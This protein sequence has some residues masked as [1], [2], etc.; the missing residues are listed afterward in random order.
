MTRHILVGFFAALFTLPAL[1]QKPPE[2]ELGFKPDKVYSFGTPENVNLFNGNLM[3]TVPI[4]LRYPVSSQMSYGLTL[5]YNSKAWDFWYDE[6]RFNSGETAAWS[7][8]NIRSN[9][10]M[11]W[12]LSLG[13][14]IPP[15]DA[16]NIGYTES[17]NKSWVY[18]GPGGDEHELTDATPTSAPT[19]SDGS[20]LRMRFVDA[21]HREIQFP[22]GEVHTFAYERQKW[23]LRSMADVAGNTVTVEYAYVLS[24]TVTSH[25]IIGD[26]HGRQHVVYFT[27]SPYLMD[28]IDRGQIVDR[29]VMRGY[30]ADVTY[31]FQYDDLRVDYT[32]GHT[33]PV[34]SSAYPDGPKEPRPMVTLL[35]SVTLPDGSKWTFDYYLTTGQ[36]CGSGLLKT[37]TL[38]TLGST[39][40]TYQQ[41]TIPANNR[42]HDDG[43]ANQSPGI[44]TRSVGEKVWTYR[45]TLAKSTPFLGAE[46]DNKCGVTPRDGEQD[47]YRPRPI[48]RWKRTSVI[49]PPH[50]GSDHTRTDHYFSL[51]RTADLEPDD[52]LNADDQQL[53]AY[54]YPATAGW[55]GRAEAAKAPVADQ[56]T[57]DVEAADN[58]GA[59]D[60]RYIQEQTWT[61]CTSNGDCSVAGATL[62]RSTYVR[63][64]NFVL[65]PSVLRHPLS[66]RTLNEDD[67]G[68][69]V[70]ENDTCYSQ[71][72]YADW[73]G[74]GH[75]RT[76][77]TSGNF[78]GAPTSVA[79]TGYI[80]IADPFDPNRKWITGRYTEQKRTMGTYRSRS[81]FHFDADTG[82]LTR[83]RALTNG[84]TQSTIDL[85]EEFQYS[86]GNLTRISSYG[87]D[88]PAFAVP[89]GSSDDL[90]QYAPP[91]SPQYR[92]D[93]LWSQGALQSERA[94]NPLSG[95]PL[96]FKTRDYVRHRTR[97]DQYGNGWS[98]HLLLVHALGRTCFDHTSG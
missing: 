50:D 8:P 33:M 64:K 24:T 49:A 45:Q 52:L 26:G 87:G 23:R 63:Y 40:Y 17:Y 25:W 92:T 97:H 44:A 34:N 78:K 51:W 35:R 5:V 16:S 27:S 21:T 77:T 41:Y 67:T 75:M 31:D 61:G 84:S 6:N 60:A 22:N 66:Q 71:T 85:H 62:L 37:V 9:A 59:A 74:L 55:P 11:G 48:F 20:Y 12:R 58:A 88:D 81:L 95:A 76:V 43:P 36:E 30:G 83:R 14:L 53:F 89:P 98:A 79:Y 46:Y 91:S 2:I 28:T 86:G 29:I 3:L 65:L 90:F 93:F 57:G 18:E 47:R 13:R 54:G 96:P 82:L 72:D 1:A 32:C 42:C 39:T 69:G 4:G 94:V 80:G 68:C 73:D 56:P 70:T 15:N 7:K 38:P 19:T 10:G